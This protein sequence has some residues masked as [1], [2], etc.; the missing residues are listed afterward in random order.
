MYALIMCYKW[1]IIH[2][3]LFELVYSFALSVFDNHVIII[4]H[5]DHSLFESAN[6]MYLVLLLYHALSVVLHSAIDLISMPD[7]D[8]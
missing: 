7:L 5:F 3:Y 2:F 1:C 6:R 4:S 8:C